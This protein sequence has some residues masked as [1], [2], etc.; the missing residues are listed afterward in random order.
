MSDIPRYTI[1][2]VEGRNL[3]VPE[4]VDWHTADW[5]ALERLG[6]RAVV[7]ADDHVA[8][9][10]ELDRKWREIAGVDDANE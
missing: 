6:G 4:G 7:L 10:N 9:M 3:L 1:I 2:N 5:D 8:A